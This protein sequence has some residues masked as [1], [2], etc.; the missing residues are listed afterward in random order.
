MSDKR[1]QQQQQ[2]NAS[3]PVFKVWWT[4]KKSVSPSVTLSV[5]PLSAR[6]DGL[7]YYVCF[8]FFFF[9]F[10]LLLTYPWLPDRLQ[11]VLHAAVPLS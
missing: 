2:Q 5:R 1:E 11:D 7:Y 6:A 4:R 9:F 8:F 3:V 10:F